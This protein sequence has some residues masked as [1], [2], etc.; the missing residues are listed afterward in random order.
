MREERDRK[1]ESEI[2]TALERMAIEAKARDRYEEQY[3]NVLDG[4]N[5]SVQIKKENPTSKIEF[6][7]TCVQPDVEKR[8]QDIISKLP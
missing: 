3:L 8:I 4:A 2:R 1:K 6:Q 5:F 7:L